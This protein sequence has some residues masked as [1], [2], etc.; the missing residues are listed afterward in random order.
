MKKLIIIL[1]TLSMIANIARAVPVQ[2]DLERTITGI[3][4]KTFSVGNLYK[5]A[6]DSTEWNEVISTTHDFV[7]EHSLQNRSLMRSY[8]KIKQANDQLVHEIDMAYKLLFRSESTRNVSNKALVEKFSSKFGVIERN[9]KELKIKLKKQ[10]DDK[11]FSLHGQEKVATVL[12]RLA[13]TLELTAK[14]ASNDLKK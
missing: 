4:T 7:K 5:T 14:K 1:C 10:L 3:H 2:K 12:H 9:M 8:K 6:M 11:K 13:L